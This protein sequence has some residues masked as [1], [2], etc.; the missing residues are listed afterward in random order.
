MVKT[1]FDVYIMVYTF[2]ENDVVLTSLTY[3]KLKIFRC[4]LQKQIDIMNLLLPP[5]LL[6]CGIVVHGN[7]IFKN[8]KF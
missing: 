7:Y 2:L 6:P 4:E 5:T 8:L 1:C 3:H